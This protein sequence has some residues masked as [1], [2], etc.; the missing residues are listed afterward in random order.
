M[1]L[2]PTK[3]IHSQADRQVK[4]DLASPVIISIS[5]FGVCS[6]QALKLQLNKIAKKPWPSWLEAAEINTHDINI[7]NTVKLENVF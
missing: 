4:N 5:L 2:A 7:L 1:G 6:Y 3:G